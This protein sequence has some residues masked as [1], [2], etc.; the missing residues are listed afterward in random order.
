MDLA[1]QMIEPVYGF[2]L[3]SFAVLLHILLL[4]YWLGADMGVFYA[5]RF[6]VNPSVSPA[7]RGVAAKVMNVVDLAPRICLVLMLP[8]GVTLMAATDLGRDVFYGWP[9]ALVW[10]AALI[11]L[12][13]VIVD[14]RRA[15]VRYADLAHR[16]DY[17]VRIALVLGLLAVSGYTFVVAEPFGVTTNPKWLAGKVAAYALCIFGGI[18]IRVKLRPF[19]PAFAKLM[20]DGSSPE[21]ERGVQGA[22]RGSIPYVLLIWVMILTATFLGVVKPGTAAVG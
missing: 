6:V 14:F 3:H 9:L 22:V 10:A 17:V 20:S 11:W 21:V 13:L 16:T 18:M 12:A 2:D 1:Q 4:T 7:A 15:P 19:G 8:S 5:S